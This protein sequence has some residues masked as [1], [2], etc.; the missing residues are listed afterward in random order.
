MEEEVSES[1]D[2]KD[3]ET[4]SAA[5]NAYAVD[6]NYLELDQMDANGVHYTLTV[7]T[8]YEFNGEICC[9]V[10]NI[11]KD[12][13]CDV[14]VPEYVT[15]GTDEKVNLP[16]RSIGENAFETAKINSV[17]LPETIRE[18]KERAFLNCTNVKT[19]NVNGKL[20]ATKKVQQFDENGNPLTD[21]NGDYVYADE[22]IKENL[23]TS[24]N[25]VN[26]TIEKEAFK[27][28]ISL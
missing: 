5:I 25:T 3:E 15:V 11:S 18:I 22:I 27:G 21:D 16:I 23:T 28:C 24:G 12:V 8:N 26:T 6:T 20:M 1:V 2:E 9:Q 14:V 10:T 19:I 7:K 4:S 17:T 13:I